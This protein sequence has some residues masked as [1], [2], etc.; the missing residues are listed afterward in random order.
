LQAMSA[1]DDPVV[2]GL[3]AAL[4]DAGCKLEQEAQLV[5]NSRG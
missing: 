1:G 2:A 4:L 5:G 3:A